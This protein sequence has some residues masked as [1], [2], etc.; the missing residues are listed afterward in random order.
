MSKKPVF[1]LILLVLL[2]SCAYAEKMDVTIKASPYSF[3]YVKTNVDGHPSSYG[4][5]AEVGFDYNIWKGLSAGA[6][7]KYS[8]YKYD[9]LHYHVISFILNAGWTQKLGDKWFLDATLGAGIQERILGEANALFFGLNLYAGAGHVISQTVSVTAGADLG[10]AFQK[11]SK[12]L[13]VD[14]MLGTVINF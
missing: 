7:V 9:D 1:I 14:V 3:Q 10:L 8:N 13:S 4:F 11:D 6:D 5:G 12:D 2:L